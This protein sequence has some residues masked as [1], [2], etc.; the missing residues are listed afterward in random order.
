MKVLTR[1]EYADTLSL[2]T[3]KQGYLASAQIEITLERFVFACY[4]SVKTYEKMEGSYKKELEWP[5][6]GSSHEVGFNE[7]LSQMLE[8]HYSN[9]MAHLV[10]KSLTISNLTYVSMHMAHLERDYKRLCSS[11]GM[12][13]SRSGR[14]LQ[15]ALNDLLLIIDRV[16]SKHIKDLAKNFFSW[17]YTKPKISVV[18]FN[19]V[20]PVGR[21]ARMVINSRNKQSSPSPGEEGAGSLVSSQ[22]TADE[23]KGARESKSRLDSERPRHEKSSD[24]NHRSSRPTGERGPRDRKPDTEKDLEQEAATLA[25]V[26]QAILTLSSTA[27]LKEVVLAPQNSYYRRL[28]HQKA[29]DAGF[30]SDSVGEGKERAVKISRS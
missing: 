29:V 12:L 26:D 21:Y 4:E 7:K 17:L 28:Q 22:E 2:E 15:V 25:L 14:P 16:F 9:H 13:D 23:P 11:S 20:P 27:D 1:E 18:D 3:V 24:R 8:W 10:E 5:H 19:Q 30:I 6:L